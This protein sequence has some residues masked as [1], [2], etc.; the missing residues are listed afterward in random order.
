MTVVEHAR[1]R[2]AN[3]ARGSERAGAPPRVA[4]AYGSTF[5]DT[6]DAAERLADG[7]RALS[8]IR[9]ELFDVAHV[10]LSRL[11]GFDVLLLGCS[12]WD[13]GE[14]QSDWAARLHELDA[15]DLRGTRVGLFGCGDQLGY[16]DSY[17]DA[18]GILAERVEARG[19]ELVGLWPATGYRHAASRAQREGTFVGLAL[20]ATSE[21]E[22]TAARVDRW[23][24]QLADELDLVAARAPDAAAAA[25]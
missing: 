9:P 23:V 11:S 7:W 18:L 5:G 14:L 3:E 19:G 13:V 25:G 22:Q 2:A 10:E 17:L 21:P 12:T 1:G 6:A 24:L 16:P 15:L 20:D 8:G 4:V